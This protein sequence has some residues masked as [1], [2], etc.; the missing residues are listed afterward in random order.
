MF[1]ELDSRCLERW[2]VI[3]GVTGVI[4][5]SIPNALGVFLALR[6]QQLSDI[7]SQ[8][9][10]PIF[11]KGLLNCLCGT[12]NQ[13]NIPVSEIVNG[14]KIIVFIANISTASDYDVPVNDEGLIVHSLIDIPE[15]SGDIN[16]LVR[17][18]LANINAGL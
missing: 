4:V 17:E 2:V 16:Q 7:N 13:Q 3:A 9:S 8:V 1:L 12:V 6:W 18:T 5:Q 10:F 14:I 15:T 11:I